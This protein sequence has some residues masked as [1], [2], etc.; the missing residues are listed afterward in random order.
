[1]KTS[2]E[3]GQKPHRGKGLKAAPASTAAVVA[4]MKGNKKRNT[5][6]ELAVRTLLHSL[7]FRYRLHVRDLP[8]N[9]D[10]VFRKRRKVIFVHGCFWHQHNSPRCRL[11]SHPKSNVA[12]WTPKLRRNKERDL[13]TRQKIAGMGWS[14]LV[15]WEC[16]LANLPAVEKRICAFLGTAQQN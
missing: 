5:R 2:K 6:P 12:Y 1:M 15:V 16:E 11:R 7:G 13:I 14:S 8:G 10:I 4:V 3:K 9:P